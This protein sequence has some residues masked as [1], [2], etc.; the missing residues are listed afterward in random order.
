MFK[1]FKKVVLVFVLSVAAMLPAMAE[2]RALSNAEYAEAVEL[3][4]EYNGVRMDKHFSQSAKNYQV[5]TIKHFNLLQEGKTVEA[6][7]LFNNVIA[8]LR[9]EIEKLPRCRFNFHTLG[10]GVIRMH[11]RVN[12]VLPAEMKEGGAYADQVWVDLSFEE[13]VRIFAGPQMHQVVL[14]QH[15]NLYKKNVVT[16]VVEGKK[17]VIGISLQDFSDAKLSKV[18]HDDELKIEVDA[19][20]IAN[21]QVFRS[22]R[23]LFKLQRYMWAK[24]DLINKSARGLE[25]GK[26]G[27]LV[28]RSFIERALSE[29]ND[30]NFSSLVKEESTLR[31]GR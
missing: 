20:S 13:L 26:A 5:Q 25:V 28:T 7:E 29:E 4:G 21:V 31:R 18:T 2:A 24:M 15:H 10:R 3:L 17:R 12:P 16:T 11:F 30:Q 8:P 6:A 19:G 1:G 22:K 14:E 23:H 9:K 27:R